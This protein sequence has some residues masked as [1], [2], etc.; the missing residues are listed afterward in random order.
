ML[1]FLFFLLYLCFL[2]FF[3]SF[4]LILF[5]FSLFLHIFVVLIDFLLFCLVLFLFSLLHYILVA[6]IYFL[7]FRLVLY[8]SLFLFSL[9]S[10]LFILSKRFEMES[11]SNLSSL[12]PLDWLLIGV[13]RIRINRRHFWNRRR[14]RFVSGKSFKKSGTSCIFLF[15]C[16][17]LLFFELPVSYSV[18]VYLF[19]LCELPS[20]RFL[21]VSL[22]PSSFLL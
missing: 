15:F 11:E 17:F 3:L 19:I 13:Q 14:S 20:I 1:Y 12:I 10:L 21:T 7:L 8:F 5:R 4:R 2:L 9:L 22:S 6:L 16:T 18:S